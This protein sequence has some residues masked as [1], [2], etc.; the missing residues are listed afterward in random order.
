M[1][2]RDAIALP[3]TLAF[4]VGGFC[5]VVAERMRSIRARTRSQIRPATLSRWQQ[6]SPAQKTLR[7]A[8]GIV[9]GIAVAV[10]LQVI[11]RV[12]IDAAYR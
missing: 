7:R 4:I 10:L 8:L 5:W 9:L 12:I 3:A 6:L 2:L 1:D 11:G